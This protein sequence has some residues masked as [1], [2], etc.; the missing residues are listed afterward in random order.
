MGYEPHMIETLAHIELL[1]PFQVL[2]KNCLV[3]GGFE[4]PA[5]FHLFCGEDFL[6]LRGGDGFVSLETDRSNLE[7]RFSI[8]FRRLRLFGFIGKPTA[9]PKQQQKDE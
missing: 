9:C 6:Q 2:R 5:K 8:I 1:D 7:L 4:K 3:E